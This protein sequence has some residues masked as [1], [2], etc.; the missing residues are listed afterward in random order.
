M[1][2]I[3]VVDCIV[4]ITATMELKIKGIL[5]L[6]E[7]NFLKIPQ[8][9]REK[10]PVYRVVFLLKLPNSKTGTWKKSIASEI[11]HVNPTTSFPTK[12][13]GIVRS[14]SESEQ[15]TLFLQT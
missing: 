4:M 11:D 1:E 7:L 2:V 12:K 14:V 5:V 15:I 10:A 6:V 3:A 9:G 8:I 13:R